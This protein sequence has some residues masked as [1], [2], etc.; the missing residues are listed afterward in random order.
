MVHAIRAPARHPLSARA[1][2]RDRDLRDADDRSNAMI[3]QWVYRNDTEAEVSTAE[4]VAFDRAVTLED[5]RILEGCDPDV[6][7]ADSD[8]R[9]DA[10]AHRLSRRRSCV[11]CSL[12]CC[13]TTARPSSVPTPEATAI[14]P[15]GGDHRVLRRGGEIAASNYICSQPKL[16]VPEKAG[17]DVDACSCSLSILA[18]QWNFAPK[19]R[20]WA[21]YQSNNNGNLCGPEKAKPRRIMHDKGGLGASEFHDLDVAS[22]SADRLPTVPLHAWCALPRVTPHAHLRNGLRVAP[23]PMLCDFQSKICGD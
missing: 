4:V 22:D 10:H 14:S 17:T 3:L 21:P 11:A 9:R 23:K 19:Q 20:I 13:R 1:D 5:K 6:P 15:P 2:P 12:N 18:D 8:G 16:A 7:L